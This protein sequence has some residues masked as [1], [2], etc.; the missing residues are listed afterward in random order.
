[1][2]GDITILAK[3]LENASFTEPFLPS[4]LS[5]MVRTKP[6]HTPWMLSKPFSNDVWY[7]VAATLF[8]TGL[9]IWYLEHK[10]NPEFNGPWWT[11]FGATFWLISSTIFFKH[12]KNSQIPFH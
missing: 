2:V 7:L 5:M 11:Q 3:R 6:D 1:M 9:I 4:G 12:G 8:Y 10:R